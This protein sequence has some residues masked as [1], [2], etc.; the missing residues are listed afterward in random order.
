M[1]RSGAR[2]DPVHAG[3]PAHGSFQ[4]TAATRARLLAAQRRIPGIRMNEFAAQPWPL[5]PQD[6]APLIAKWLI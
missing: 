1:P 5:G 4:G 3:F 2:G 6:N